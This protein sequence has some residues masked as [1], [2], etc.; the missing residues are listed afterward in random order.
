MA[1]GTGEKPGGRGDELGNPPR[2]L[3]DSFFKAVFGDPGLAAD[4]LRA[5][6]PPEVAEHIDWDTLAP[7]PANFVDEVFEQRLGDLVFR[8]GLMDGGEV[9]L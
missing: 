6:L 4:E 8:A 9:F 2:T 5:V 1:D 3:H 7:A